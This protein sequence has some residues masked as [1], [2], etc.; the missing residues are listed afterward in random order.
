M[1]GCGVGRTK[2]VNSCGLEISDAARFLGGE[3]IVVGPFLD[4]DGFGVFAGTDAPG[5]T[6]SA[7]G[8]I[9][10]VWR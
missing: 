10:R 1:F 9:L 5:A 3:F 6:L 2:A 7:S 4:S 8:P